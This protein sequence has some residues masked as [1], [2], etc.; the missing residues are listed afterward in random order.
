MGNFAIEGIETTSRRRAF[1]IVWGVSGC[2]LLTLAIMDVVVFTLTLISLVVLLSSLNLPAR[3]FLLIAFIPFAHAGIGWDLLRGFGIY[4]LYTFWFILLFLG[5]FVMK[6]LMAFSIP[7]VFKL[8]LLMFIGFIPSL[9]STPSMLISLKSFLQLGVSILTSLGLYYFLVQE[10]S[11][12]IIVSLLKFYALVAVMASAMGLYQA[13]TATSL[14]QV[15]AGRVFLTLFGEVNYYAGYLL[16]SIPLL[17][18]FTLSEAKGMVRVLFL[19]GLI[20]N[21]LGLVATISRSAF[22]TLGV[23]LLLYMLYFLIISR[24]TRRVIGMVMLLG[25]VVLVS[26]FVVTNLGR[27]IVDLVALSDRLTMVLEGRDRSVGQRQAILEVALRAIKTHPINGVG[28]GAFEEVFDWYKE[29]D[30]STGF[31]RSVHNT[32]LRILAETGVIGFIPAVTFVVVLLISLW[33]A[34]K[35]CTN[36]DEQLLAFSLLMAIVSFLVMSM[37]LDQMFEPH[38]WIMAGFALALAKSKL[39]S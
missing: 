31:A 22:V 33:N 9:L 28:Y 27:T 15:A 18:A 37:T 8:A 30:L 16:T 10:E 25:C 32:G 23:V 1:A 4:D 3:I 5:R 17:L 14:F 13:V 7:L 6:D 11:S 21:V 29:A 20:I 38:F 12:R 24:G 36:E 26:L 19:I 34:M 35:R 2:A 39:S